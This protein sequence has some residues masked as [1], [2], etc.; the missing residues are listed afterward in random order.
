M[1][2]IES[3]TG[4]TSGLPVNELVLVASAPTCVRNATLTEVWKTIGSADFKDPIDPKF[5][6]EWQT[7]PNPVDPDFFA[8]VLQETAK[9]PA[10]VWKATFRGLLTDDHSA[11]LG[12]IKAPV[13]IIWGD[14]DSIFLRPDQDAL[15]KAIP[16]ATLKVYAGAGHNVQWEQGRNQQ[17][18]DDIRAF[19][20]KP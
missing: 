2:N 20:A 1:S 3:L 17:V 4:Q 12:D 8:K 9:P 16:G 10:R 6:Q 5:I 19:L 15:M 13:L 14:K 11:F 7:G 18:A